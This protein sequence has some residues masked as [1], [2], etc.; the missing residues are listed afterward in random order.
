[1]D[2]DFA[3]EGDSGAL[4]FCKSDKGLV[5]AGLLE[6][7][8]KGYTIMTPICDILHAVGYSPPYAPKTFPD[9]NDNIN[10][11][12]HIQKNSGQRTKEEKL[13]AAKMKVA[14]GIE[15]EKQE[16]IEVPK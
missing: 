13:L 5:A 10:G 4:V 2:L 15:A 11:K 16:S 12:C 1:M 14:S 3:A 7:G 6:G 9:A 8:G